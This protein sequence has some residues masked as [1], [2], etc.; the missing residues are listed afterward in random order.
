LVCEA[1]VFGRSS[2]LVDKVSEVGVGEVH[3]F[4]DVGKTERTASGGRWW[5]R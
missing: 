3:K 1:K 4:V 2:E 5:W